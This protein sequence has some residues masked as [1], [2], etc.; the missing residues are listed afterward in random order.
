MA[1]SVGVCAK[2]GHLEKVW[3]RCACGRGLHVYCSPFASVD[4]RCCLCAIRPLASWRKSTVRPRSFSSIVH[5]GLCYGTVCPCYAALHEA[6]GRY[7][8]RPSAPY[9]ACAF[10]LVWTRSFRVVR[11]SEGLFM[12]AYAHN[13]PQRLGRGH[14]QQVLVS[15]Q[16]SFPQPFQV[17]EGQLHLWVHQIKAR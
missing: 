15:L 17:S 11:E 10:P 5:S 9:I 16:G 12:L 6:P 8:P 2:T 3:Y 7:G 13:L 14:W 4:H 1:G